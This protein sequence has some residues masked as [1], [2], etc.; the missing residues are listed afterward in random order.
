MRFGVVGFGSMGKRRAR[1]LSAAGH[2]IVVYDVRADRCEA[3]SGEFGHEVRAS[4]AEL[5]DSALDALV[6]STPPDTHEELA[7]AAFDAGLPFFLEASIAVP[8]PAWVSRRQTETRAI[9]V[10]SATWRFHPL[11]MALKDRIRGLPVLAVHHQYAGF[12][13]SWH[14]DERY[15]EFYAGRS[16]ETCAAR[17]MVP[18]ELD[19]LTWLFGPVS[20]VSAQRSRAREWRT[21]IVDTYLLRLVFEAGHYATLSIEL[22]QPAPVRHLRVGLEESAIV[23]DAVAGSLTDCGPGAETIVE[24]HDPSWEPVYAS[25]MAAFVDALSGGPYPKNWVE[26]RHLYDVLVAAERS[27]S[28]GRVER[29]VADN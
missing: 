15:D 4:F 9:A 8:S 5:T 6:I 3:A 22:H 18:F 2:D 28:S 14:A 17:E 19:V 24:R 11:T 27:S 29:V 10:P 20:T 26:E 12:L 16:I 1:D 25:E 13:P 23:L 7:G 21:D